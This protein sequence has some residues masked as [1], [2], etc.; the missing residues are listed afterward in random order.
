MPYRPS[1]LRN[2]KM[3]QCTRKRR[4][5][6]NSIPFR[7]LFASRNK[8]SVSEFLIFHLHIPQLMINVQIHNFNRDVKRSY[9]TV[10]SFFVGVVRLSDLPTEMLVRI[11]MLMPLPD[12]KKEEFRHFAEGYETFATCRFCGD[13]LNTTFFTICQRLITCLSMPKAAHWY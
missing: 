3:R 8:Y 13:I 9:L 2:Q 10:L 11:F 6:S 7:A 5:Q 4:C 1:T 12:L